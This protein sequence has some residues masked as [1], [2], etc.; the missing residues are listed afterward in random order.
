MPVGSASSSSFVATV[1]LRTL[2]VSTSG[3]APLTV[4][5]SSIEPTRRSPFTVAVNPAESW[6]PSRLTVLNPGRLK[7]TVYVPGRKSMRL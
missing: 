5:V 1:C 2:V 7:V 4:T 3:D 6:M